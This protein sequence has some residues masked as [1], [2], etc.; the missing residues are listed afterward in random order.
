MPNPTVEQARVL[1]NTKKNLVVSASAGSGKTWVMIEYITK[2]IV[3][4][5]IP[6]RRMLILTFTRAAA[7]EMRER[8]NKALLAVK[9]DAFIMQQ[10][11]DLSICDVSTIDAFC[12]KLIKR[13]IDKLNID[14]TFRLLDEPLELKRKAFDQAINAF[15]GEELNEIYYSFRKNKDMIFDV[16]LNLDDFFAVSGEDKQVD[17]YIENQENSFD[18]A[19]KELNVLLKSDIQRLVNKIKGIQDDIDIKTFRAIYTEAEAKYSTFLENL[20]SIISL[21]LGEDFI[22]NAKSLQLIEVPSVPIVR[23]EGRDESLAEFVKGV[24]KEV[25]DF[26]ESF[27][28]YDFSEIGLIRQRK[29]TLSVAL[30]KL[31]KEF[32]RQYTLLKQQQDVLDFVELEKL[33]LKLLKEEDILSLLQEQYDYIFVDEY[34]DTNRIQE[35]IIKPITNKGHFVAVGDPKQGIYGFRNA[36]MEIMQDDVANFENAENGGVEYLR[37]NFRSDDR[38]LQFINRVFEKVMTQK[39]VGID[40]KATSMLNG[41]IPF[42][43][44]TLPSVRVD[45]VEDSEKT[46]RERGGIYSVRDD[47]LYLNEKNKSEVAAIVARIDELLMQKIYDAKLK[48]FRQVEFDDIAV[49]LR[50]RSSLMGDLTRELECRGYPVLSDLKELEIEEPEVQMLVNLL[51]LLLNRD[52]DIALISV[53]NSCFG[54][55]S[56]DELASIRIENSEAKS[57]YEIFAQSALPKITEFN[58]MLSSLKLSAMVNGLYQSLVKL[59]VKKDYFAYL[60]SQEGGELKLKQVYNFLHDLKAYDRDIPGA[61]SYFNEVGG[62]KRNNGSSGS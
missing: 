20:L 41:E 37:G 19:L 36:T 47:E 48:T 28:K 24:R 1:N 62:K 27:G 14:E 29:G 16:I 23:G 55:L 60:K 22:S 49:L 9:G 52:D 2:L 5:H 15:S 3:E 58:D 12:E 34:Q 30:L 38:L 25:K 39:S 11:D 59:M 40:Y 42:E 7:G 17:Y 4:K 54:G 26:V 56:F 53:L 43:K 13:N 18:E 21:P 57:F 8:L 50:S 44:M 6:V 10:L 61:I 33:A 31:Y 35:A 51:K 32:A 45:I 46:T